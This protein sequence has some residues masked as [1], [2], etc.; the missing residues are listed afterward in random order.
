MANLMY[1]AFPEHLAKGD[2]DLD[3][4]T[5]Y[6]ALLTSSY[7][8]TATHEA[9]SDLTNEVA[10]GNGYATGGKAL[11]S[12]TVAESGGVTTLDAA[13]MQWAGSTY[14]CQY[15]AIYDYT[16]AGKY[17]ICVLDLGAKSPNS[18]TFTVQF[19]T[20]GILTFQAS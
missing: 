10:N 1:N 3:T 14:S 8:P 4:H 18:S 6:G 9:Y 13:D 15:L 2:I 5:L 20:D 17:L 19:H 12:V 7:T 16:A 11:T